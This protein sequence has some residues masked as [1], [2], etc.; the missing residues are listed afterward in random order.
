M[1]IKKIFHTG[2]IILSFGA[3]SMTFAVDKIDSADFIDEVSAK[4]IAEIESARLALEK[5]TSVTITSFAQKMITEHA[6]TNIELSDIA[7]RKN[8]KVADQA[9]LTEKAKKFILMQREGQ[10]FNEAYANNQ[11][12]SHKNLIELYQRASISNDETLAIFAKQTLPRLQQHLK[13]AKELAVA[14]DKK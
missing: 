1:N 10:S 2:L 14:N 9:E 6:A 11:V 13:E 5:T 8:I 3:S 7:A 12:E 4:N